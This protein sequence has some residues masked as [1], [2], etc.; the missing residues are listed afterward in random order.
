MGYLNIEFLIGEAK[1]R[2]VT[3]YDLFTPSD[4][5]VDAGKFFNEIVSNTDKYY[6]DSPEERILKNTEDNNFY[7]VLLNY[8]D[9]LGT[10]NKYYPKLEPAKVRKTKNGLIPS[11]GRHRAK[12]CMMLNIKLPVVVEENS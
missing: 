10:G 2:G 1:D 7:K 4:G 8:L 9:S 5:L 6:Q 11:D 12:F 3:P